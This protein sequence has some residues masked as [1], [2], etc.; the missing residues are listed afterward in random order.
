MVI[1]ARTATARADRAFPALALSGGGFRATL[2]HCGA[3]L[4]LNELGYLGRIRRLSSVSGGSIAAGMLAAVW[5][6]LRWQD[7]RVANLD[8]EVIQP[9]R[10]FCHRSI[11]KAAIGW[12]VLTPGKSIGDVLADIYDD[13]FEGVTLQQLPDEPQFI[14]K[15][16]N[17][18][19]GRLVRFSKLRLGPVSA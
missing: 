14:V 5:P 9:L 8:E 11:D 13:L 4:R 16:T 17:L 12:G 18:Q 7:G 10:A 15:A 1:E 2:F 6:R 3:L 19:T